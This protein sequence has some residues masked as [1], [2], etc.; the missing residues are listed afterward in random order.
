MSAREAVRQFIKDGDSV[1]ISGFPHLIPTALG[2]EII[3]QGKKNLILIKESPE[4]LGDLMVGAGCV[5]KVVFGFMGIPGM[6]PCPEIRR[7]IEGKSNFAL[8]VEEYTHFAFCTAIKAGAQGLPFLPIR[9]NLGS[10]YLS[11]NN[12]LKIMD[13]PFTGEKLCLVPAIKADVALL[14]AQRADQKGNIQ[15]WGIL[16]LHREMALAAR[17]VIVSVEEIV[18]EED[19]RR[20]PDRT[21]IPGF[22]VDAVVEE[23]WG[24]HPS[25]VQGYYDRDEG[26]YQFYAQ[27]AK[28][29]DG[30]MKYLDE[31]VLGVNDRKGYLEKLGFARVLA[32]KARSFY[33]YSVNYG[34]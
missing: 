16:G 24:A 15:A 7:A 13:C 21:I 27:S 12:K 22:K 8:E 29:R 14:H 6:G 25:Y 4:V 18:P 26:M 31:W 17:K 5:K 11:V 9:T 2:H 20:D 1:L 30:F 28:T 33:G 23:P 34:Y 10:D 3:R 32:L 19:I